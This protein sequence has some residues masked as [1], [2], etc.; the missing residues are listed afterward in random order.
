[1]SHQD[2]VTKYCR[3]VLSGRILSGIYTKKAVERYLRDL[4]RQKEPSFLYEYC[5]DLADEVMDFAESLQIPDIQR[6]D[7]SKNLLLLPWMKFIYA[8]IWG[9]R[10]KSDNNIRRFRYGYCEVARKNSKT[11]SI[12]FP[13]VLWDF[14]STDS[15]ESYFVSADG[16][17]SDKSYKELNYIIKADKDLSKH[18]AST[19]NAVTLNHSR[20]AF[21]SSES[22][23]IDSYK[24]SMSIIDE[25][26]SYSSDKIVTA[27]RYGGRA[28]PNNLVMI[29]T[30]AGND[31]SGPCYAEALRCKK[32]LNGAF[33]DETYFGIIYAYDDEDKWDDPS[34]FIK[35]NPSLGTFLKQ[36]ILENDMNDALTLPA[37]QPDFKSK[38]CGIWTSAVSNWIPLQK[39][40]RNKNYIF[41]E[42]EL[43]RRDCFGALDL[44]SVN[45]FTALTLYFKL[46]DGK[47][48]PKHWFYVPSMTVIN[49]YKKENINILA[50]IQNG[51]V[52]SIDGETIDQSVIISDILS[53]AEKYHIREIACD[54]WQADIVQNAVND[55]L[56]SVVF[57]FPQGLEKMGLPTQKWEK[58]ILDGDI[59]DNNPVMQWM[60]GN[61]KIKINANGFYKPLKEY[62]SSGNRIDG[63]ITSI[64]AFD[65]LTV[66]TSK[67]TREY[68]T[69]D[70][71]ASI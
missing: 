47:Y 30:S 64:M 7:G 19:V 40:E 51:I 14:I 45:D 48:Y 49:R 31:I 18:T 21:F 6:E 33:D 34:L 20:I 37:H 71:L 1:M 39:W 24:N 50:W 16:L 4:K 61:A 11:T 65:R 58:A 46:D 63:V 59:V 10:L 57:K 66:N 44:S 55:K 35:A 69:E 5:P 17:Q 15:A 42:K 43:E 9:W 56:G 25:Y 52:T 26:H 27:F 38:T 29:I 28:R 67:P 23:G 13:W 53:L 54:P 70:L 2:D 22:M 12:L 36:E 60:I 8:N 62:A 41:D 32:I 3:D 68:S